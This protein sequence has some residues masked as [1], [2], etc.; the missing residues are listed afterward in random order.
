MLPWCLIVQIHLFAQP[1]DD[2]VELPCHHRDIKRLIVLKFSSFR[3]IYQLQLTQIKQRKK[4]ASFIQRQ[5]QFLVYT[6]TTRFTV[7]YGYL[8]SRLQNLGHDFT[9][10]TGN[11][12]KLHTTYQF[13]ISLFRNKNVQGKNV[14]YSK[15][16]LLYLTEKI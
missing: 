8:L 16:D 14:C 12:A 7:L 13:Y 6:L 5:N 10:A 11:S 9:L 3:K 15:I 2:W 4:A 1:Q